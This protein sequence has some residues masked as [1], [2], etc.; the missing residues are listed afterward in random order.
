MDRQQARA[1][2]LAWTRLARLNRALNRM[3]G[4]LPRHGEGGAIRPT[5]S[6]LEI[7]FA[8]SLK[9][10][11]EHEV[12]ELLALYRTQLQLLSQHLQRRLRKLEWNFPPVYTQSSGEGILSKSLIYLRDEVRRQISLTIALL[13]EARDTTSG[14]HTNAP[15]IHETEEG[16]V[17]HFDRD[18][19][20]RVLRVLHD[21]ETKVER[22]EYRLLVLGTVKAG[23][24]TTIAG[25]TGVDILPVRS[26]ATTTLPTLVRNE[27]GRTIPT[28][29]LRQAAKVRSF[30]EELRRGTISVPDHQLNHGPRHTYNLIRD[31]ATV[32]DMP[33]EG[34]QAI[35]ETISLLN[36]GL[37]LAELA[38]AGP[39][40]M[41]A[42]VTSDDLPIIDVEFS[43]LSGVA[44]IDV[45]GRIVLVDSPGPNETTHSESLLRIVRE[46]IDRASALVV[47]KNYTILEGNDEDQMRALVESSATLTDKERNILLL[48]RYDQAREGEDPTPEEMRD[49]LAKKHPEFDRRRIFAVSAVRAALSSRMLR[50]L[51]ESEPINDAIDEDRRLLRGFGPIAFGTDYRSKD[52]SFRD[53]ERLREKTV[54]VWGLSFFDTV[55]DDGNEFHTPTDEEATF[56]SCLR[57]LAK[58]AARHC[59]GA[60]LQVLAG[61]NDTLHGVL[62]QRGKLAE[63]Q[64]HTL[65]IESEQIVSD[66]SELERQ[67][68]NLNDLVETAM[69]ELEAEVNHLGEELL[70][71][72]QFELNRIFNKSEQEAVE[73]AEMP[74]R[75]RGFISRVMNVFRM[76]D[77]HEPVESENNSYASIELD[78]G[79]ADKLR[80]SISI[81]SREK[82]D[83][84]Q[85]KLETA[86][87]MFVER[88]CAIC[89]QKIKSAVKTIEFGVKQ[90]VEAVMKVTLDKA[91]SR[92]GESFTR[93][94][95]IDLEADLQDA[96]SAGVGARAQVEVHHYQYYDTVNQDG[97]WGAIK[98]DLGDLFGKDDWGKERVLRNSTSYELDPSELSRIH[99]DRVRAFQTKL[100]KSVSDYISR[101]LKSVIQGYHHEM[102]SYLE[103]YRTTIS[104]TLS[105]HTLDAQEREALRGKII[106]LTERVH[107]LIED[108]K[109]AMDVHLGK[110]EVAA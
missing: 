9:L 80:Y 92:L 78:S 24:S 61:N 29:T 19:L 26:E 16:A 94:L 83:E 23:K 6:A 85:D 66:I 15:L 31:G 21:E 44:M 89:H 91:R 74:K 76:P 49:Q 7:R 41:E 81:S 39:R 90:H 69:V 38:D 12:W 88:Q 106:S 8:L 95:T 58:N 108:I 68:E 104:D 37:R 97:I 27:A 55:H 101:D 35:R 84:I 28:M 52:A 32:P 102:V 73:R 51:D 65:I 103:A 70:Q 79:I 22:F 107:Q 5:L 72:V 98:R 34:A 56:L 60:A 14:V 82:A 59:I 109:E 43:S 11:K 64:L 36:D 46:Q 33:V 57:E 40:Y 105:D 75:A 2:V 87:S 50:R 18:D 3:N 25:I 110:K 4:L 10:G 30:F 86:V 53:P 17:R 96:A 42:F 48:N 54:S 62:T 63:D 67:K 45:L 13:E 99:L 47:V 71:H 1:G 100:Q 20:E 77:N 93:E